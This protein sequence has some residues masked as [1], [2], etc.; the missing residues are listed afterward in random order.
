MYVDPEF[1]A[2]DSSLYKNTVQP[3]MYASPDVQW[4]RPQEIYQ[5]EGEPLMMKDGFSPGDVK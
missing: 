3:P 1:D 2:D 5:G 4:K